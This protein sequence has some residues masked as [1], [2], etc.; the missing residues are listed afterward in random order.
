MFNNKNDDVNIDVRQY[1][2]DSQ[3]Q[4]V[5]K[6]K[7]RIRQSKKRIF[8]LYFPTLLM[9]IIKK[10]LFGFFKLWGGS[11]AVLMIGFLYFTD[12]HTAVYYNIA[13]TYDKYELDY[14][15][16]IID[17][18]QIQLEEIK[19]FLE[20]EKLRVT[21]REVTSKCNKEQFKRMG[22]WEEVT[23]WFCKKQNLILVKK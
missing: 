13:M 2:Q 14:S 1:W 6:I 18:K 11:V 21:K 4:K 20:K 3:E 16:S 10:T 5:K 8:F 9:K 12:S 17:K 7:K 19:N 15:N 23:I 22:Q